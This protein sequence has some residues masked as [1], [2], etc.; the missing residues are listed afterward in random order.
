M[1]IGMLAQATGVSRE[2]LRFYEQRGLLRA[3]RLGNGYRDYPQA[4]VLLVQYIRN[5]QR[6]GFTLAEISARLPDIWD[7]PDPAQKVME[8]LQLKLQ[9]LDQRI[10][11]LQ[12]LR[13]QLAH[14]IVQQCPLLGERTQAPATCPPE[15]AQ[16]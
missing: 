7:A 10:L 5:A 9:E 1:K 3:S 8:V 11:A 6:L 4:S 15:W 14:E 2:T 13:Q 16:Q 12:T